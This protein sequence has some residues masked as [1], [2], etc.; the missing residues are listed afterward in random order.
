VEVFDGERSQVHLFAMEPLPDDL[1]EL[2]TP[3]VLR[4]R[5]RRDDRLTALF[6]RWPN[7][8]GRELRELRRVSDERLR[9]ARYIG[10]LRARRRRPVPKG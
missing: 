3:E 1:S 9:L 10:K 6:R 2:D 7:L 8:P 4:A 5:A